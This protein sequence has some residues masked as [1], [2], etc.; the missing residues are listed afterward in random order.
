M[1]SGRG[2]VVCTYL[3]TPDNGPTLFRMAESLPRLHPCICAVNGMTGLLRY[4]EIVV[5]SV[6]G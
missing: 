3:R 6:D 4:C 5:F 1:G 2:I